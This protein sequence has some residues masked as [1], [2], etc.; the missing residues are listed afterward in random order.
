MKNPYAGKPDHQF[1]RRVVAGKGPEEVDPVVRA[2][3]SIARTDRV[4][5]AGSCFAQHIGRHLQATGFRYFV[6]E[7][8]PAFAFSENENYGLFSARYGNVYTVRQLWQLFQRAYG[9]FTPADVVWRRGDGRVIDPFR[10]RIASE[11]FASADELLADRLSHLA[12][13]RRVFEESDV[14][15][16][17]L[18]LTEGW[19]SLD[20]GAVFPLS[21]GTVMT[22][23]SAE[24][25]AFRNF[26]VAE[27]DADL[28]R[29]I[30]ALR[31]VNPNC[32]VL[33]TVSPVALVAT[34]EDKHVLTATIY[35]KSALRVVSEIATQ[36]F[37]SVAYFPSYEMIIGPQA[38]S[39]F[40]EDD[41]REVRSAGVAYV[42][43][44][45]AKHYLS[46]ATPTNTVAPAGPSRLLRD[47]EVAIREA[48][49]VVCDEEQIEQS[50]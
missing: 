34:Y 5:T 33:L 30:R 13:V 41:L 50:T 47:Q 8:R 38:R 18:G 46:S 32:R 35:S 15:I 14:F 23:G 44:V 6:P 39:A 37:P 26:T 29:F 36:S 10:P 42:M 19:I 11:G 4:S 9:L 31:S 43:S 48:Q 27:M 12:A 20:D 17:T 49:Q 25:Y 24:A 1:W 21:P 28:A 2:P 22:D 7:N 45:F 3:F 16:F 40:F